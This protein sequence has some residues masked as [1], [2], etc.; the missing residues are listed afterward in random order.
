VALSESKSQ[1]VSFGGG[2]QGGTNSFGGR[3]LELGHT[4]CILKMKSLPSLILIDILGVG[5]E[6]SC[7]PQLQL[8]NTRLPDLLLAETFLFP[9]YAF[10]IRNGM[11]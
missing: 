3:E 7:H 5:E 6:Y 1:I 2:G 9:S 10:F 11:K 4:V 8:R